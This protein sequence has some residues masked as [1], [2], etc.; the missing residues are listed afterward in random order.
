MTN[1]LD[2]STLG[3]HDFR[4]N[5][6]RYQQEYAENNQN[7]AASFAQIAAEKG[8]TPAQLA[9]AWVLAQGENIIPIPGT[10]RRKYLLDNAGAV[11]VALSSVDL[12]LLEDL[13]AK[14]P[15]VG[16]RY[17][18]ENLQYVDRN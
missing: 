10:K 7:L 6:P 2:I 4:K 9:I 8:C 11:D 18:A 15:H 17:N 3:T 14:Y 5:L 12:A 1:T 16:P 13:L